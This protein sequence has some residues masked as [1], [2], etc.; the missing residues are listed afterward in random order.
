MAERRTLRCF[1]SLAVGSACVRC[2]HCVHGRASRECPATAT[3]FAPRFS[4]SLKVSAPAGRH[5]FRGHRHKAAE[6]GGERAAAH[7]LLPGAGH[8]AHV[9]DPHLQVG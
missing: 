7:L 4:L 1:P 8:A 9:S 3:Y 6:G 5:P 2:V